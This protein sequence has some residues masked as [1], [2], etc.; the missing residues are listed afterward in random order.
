MNRM[1][2]KGPK[3]CYPRGGV[4]LGAV[5]LVL[6]VSGCTTRHLTTSHAERQVRRS[7]SYEAGGGL[8]VKARN[9]SVVVQA[10]PGRDDV[11]IEAMLRCSGRTKE[12]ARRRAREAELIVERDGAGRLAV[13]PAFPGGACG[14]DAASITLRLPHADAGEVRLRSENGEIRVEGL[15]GR[16]VVENSND[17]ITVIGHR[18]DARLTSSNGEITVTDHEGTVVADTSNDPIII[19]GQRGDV[20]LTSSNGRISVRD[21]DGAVVA[22]TSNDPIEVTL[23]AGSR[24]PLDLRTSNNPISATVAPDFAG[25]VRFETSNDG[26][27]LDT[28]DAARLRRVS[29]GEEAGLIHLGEAGPRSTLETSNDPIRFTVRE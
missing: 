9:G 20:R 3:V 15:A 27:E 1:R 29:L 25:E 23:A 26:I 4:V 18:G 17:P 19:R 10:E 7:A 24:G 16:L 2:S 12:E 11:A 22:Q 6:M 5:V 21:H 14:S 13:R 28:G 8:H